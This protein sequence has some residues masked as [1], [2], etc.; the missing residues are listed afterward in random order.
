MGS[1]YRAFDSCSGPGSFLVGLYGQISLLE[2][3]R[4]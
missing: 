2:T 3:G 1:I 4:G